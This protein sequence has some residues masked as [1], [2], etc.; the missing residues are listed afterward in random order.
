MSSKLRLG[1]IISI[2]ICSQLLNNL[3][4]YIYDCV[5]ISRFFLLALSI[6]YPK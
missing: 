4:Q 1:D 5:K 3:E 2:G 6:I